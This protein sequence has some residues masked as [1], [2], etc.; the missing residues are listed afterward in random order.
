MRKK[1]VEE[2]LHWKLREEFQAFMTNWFRP[3][4]AKVEEMKKYMHRLDMAIDRL[5]NQMDVVWTTL[6]LPRE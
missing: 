6:N 5:E 1:K 3:L 4:E 2:L